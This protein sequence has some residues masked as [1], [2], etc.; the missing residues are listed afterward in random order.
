MWF[1][2]LPVLIYVIG[3]RIFNF[4]LVFYAI[5]E[6]HYKVELECL[7]NILFTLPALLQHLIDGARL[8]LGLKG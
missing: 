7:I 3:S 2:A 4:S 1:S 5:I 6:L 8:H